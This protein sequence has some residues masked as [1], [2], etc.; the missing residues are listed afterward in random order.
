MDKKII[1]EKYSDPFAA[2]L[3]DSKDKLVDVDDD[4]DDDDDDNSDHFIQAKFGHPMMMMVKPPL[5]INGST[6][7]IPLNKENTPSYLHNLWYGHTNFDITN[8][9]ALTIEKFPGVEYLRICSRYRFLVGFGKAFC[10]LDENNRIYDSHEIRNGLTQELCHTIDN[11]E[12]GDTNLQE[13]L[14]N[15][16]KFWLYVKFPNN[17]MEVIGSNELNIEFQE[18]IVTCITAALAVNAELVK[19]HSLGEL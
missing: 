19:S 4:D 5:F 1:W 7:P 16:Y 12:T 3:D 17:N 9:V 15:K 18:K 6:G 8:S 10:K 13:Q 14:N 11:L 2:F